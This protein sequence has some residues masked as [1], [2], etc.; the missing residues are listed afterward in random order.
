MPQTGF[1]CHDKI[2]GGYYADP[3]AQCQMFHVCVKV[4]GVGVQ[5]FRFLCPNGTA[6]DQEVQIC[7]NWGDVDCEEA[8]LYYGSDNFDLYRIGS[9]FESKR[10]PLAE[11]E[12][13][14]FHLQRA[15]T[16]DIRR[17]KETQVDQKLR[18]ENAAYTNKYDS[19]T[20]NSFYE[21]NSGNRKSNYDQNNDFNKITSKSDFPKKVTSGYYTTPK[22][23]DINSNSDS[24]QDDDLFKGSHSSNFFSNRNGGREDD[25]YD[26]PVTSNTAS[27]SNGNGPQNNIND[28]NYDETTKRP[29]R[30]RRPNQNQ[31]Q[32]QNNQNILTS[33]PTKPTSTTA[34]PTTKRQTLQTSFNA[35]FDQQNQ[36]PYRP[37]TTTTTT[38]QRSTSKTPK[39][40]FEPNDY[41]QNIQPTTYNPSGAFRYK[42]T[43]SKYEEIDE[44]ALRGEKPGQSTFLNSKYESQKFDISN[45]KSSNFDSNFE[46]QN[47]KNSTFANR[48]EFVDYTK[49]KTPSGFQVSP[50]PTIP[51]NQSPKAIVNLNEQIL[52]PNSLNSELRNFNQ[53]VQNQRR[54]SNNR[55]NERQ[56]TEPQYFRSRTLETPSPFAVTPKQQQTNE[57]FNGSPQ[58]EFSRLKVESVTPNGN[59]VE[60]L[61]KPK[62][63]QIPKT[64]DGRNH[65]YLPLNQ[66]NQ[67]KPEQRSDFD[68]LNP[69]QREISRN[70]PDKR[71]GIEVNTGLQ[72]QSQSNQQQSSFNGNQNPPIRSRTGVVEKIEPFSTN[73][74]NSDGFN[75]PQQE[76]R[77]I[78]PRTRNGLVSNTNALKDSFQQQ[79]DAN[80]TTV[81]PTPKPSRGRG[82]INYKSTTQQQSEFQDNIIQSTTTGLKKFS[83]LVTKDQY[84]P[85]TFKPTTYKK[86]FEQKPTKYVDPKQRGTPYT[87]TTPLP[88]SASQSF[89]SSPP[90]EDDGQYHPE[91]YEVDD[92]QNY[93]FPNNNN[94]KQSYSVPSSITSHQQKSPPKSNTQTTRSPQ[95]HLQSQQQTAFQKQSYQSQTHQQQQ[96]QQQQ[97]PHAIPTDLSDEEELF[98]TAHS[99]N[100]GA[101]SINKLRSDTL[102][103]SDKG[104]A[105]QSSPSFG[106]DRTTTTYPTTITKVTSP[107][108]TTTWRSTT[109]YFTSTT[110]TSRTSSASK[111]PKKSSAS[112]RPPHADADT[113]YD[114]AYYDSLSETPQEYSEYD[115]ISEFRKTTKKQ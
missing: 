60:P 76:V 41:Q 83:T 67:A 13:S 88:S 90:D 11:E 46:K 24:K 20:K 30:S 8:V 25:F 45:K 22:G 15:E 7:A 54:T 26:K 4:A 10:A 77:R 43:T 70:R 81:Q 93:D 92:S 40:S 51:Q 57:N 1:T 29:H 16:G 96:D 38:T 3:E 108:T 89:N 112:K 19:T 14:T 95:S 35:G 103:T 73:Q 18:P 101:A 102:K 42:S 5:D 74:F 47:S 2:L 68:G 71:T 53:T 99:L 65:G 39:F 6:F 87:T 110:K 113:S 55:F 66:G 12:E 59:N 34:F 49:N 48:N 56:Q 84:N 33:S 97:H 72:S 9:S 80:T 98:K 17:S 23:N 50:R 94:K 79:S 28:F 37:S 109:D 58:R 91:L 63:Q 36:Q 114:Y 27:K 105:Q 100:L 111:K 82:R 64:F 75:S 104:T 107:I 32:N 86:A 52:D 62:Q 61:P 78:K 31:N 21:R 85:T 44:T 106:F 69:P 115:V